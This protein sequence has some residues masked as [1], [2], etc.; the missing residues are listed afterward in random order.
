MPEIH[1]SISATDQECFELEKI[2]YDYNQKWLN[3]VNNNDTSIYANLRY[4]TK[5]YEYAM[6]Y[7]AKNVVESYQLLDVNDVR[8]Y[9]NYYY[10]WTHE[11]ITETTSYSSNNLEY[12]WVY[13][14]G[15]DGSGYYVENYTAD[16]YYK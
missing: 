11:I 14:I 1:N 9:G 15:K 16:P 13:K 8:K 10:V 6:K 7:S 3:F 2:V 4:G 12:Y 5:A